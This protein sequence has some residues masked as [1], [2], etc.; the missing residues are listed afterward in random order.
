MGRRQFS[1][2]SQLNTNTLRT[3]KSCQYFLDS[4]AFL[5]FLVQTIYTAL[6][7]PYFSSLVYPLRP[8][9]RSGCN[10]FLAVGFTLLDVCFFHY[11]NYSAYVVL[12][13]LQKGNSNFKVNF[14][15]LLSRLLRFS[16]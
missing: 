5:S 8:I 10:Y 15:G 2:D 7:I 12:R 1:S 3:T 6:Q 14:L 4:C 11:Y 9:L 16:F 13:R